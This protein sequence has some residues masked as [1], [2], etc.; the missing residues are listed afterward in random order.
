MPRK[1][2]AQPLDEAIAQLLKKQPRS[3]PELTEALTGATYWAIK[4]TVDRMEKRGEVVRLEERKAKSGRSEPVYLYLPMKLTDFME[5]VDT[6][7]AEE[8]KAGQEVGEDVIF[9]I[10]TRT[11][12]DPEFDEE[13]RLAYFKK[14]AVLL[15]NEDPRALL[16]RFGK[17]LFDVHAHS[18]AAYERA[19][20]GGGVGS[21]REE[22]ERTIDTVERMV[23]VVFNRNLGI[24][25]IREAEGKPGNAELRLRFHK[26]PDGQ[27]VRRT[28][29]AFVQDAVERRLK[30]A[31]VGGT[32]LEKIKVK[33]TERNYSESGTDASVRKFDLRMLPSA[34]ERTRMAI[35]TAAAVRLNFNSEAP[36]EI[37]ARPEPR[38]W[39]YYTEDDAIDKGLLIPPDAYLLLDDLIWERLGSAAMNLR[40][41]KKDSECFEQDKE[42]RVPDILFR[43]GRIFPLE[44]LFDDYC[45][46]GIHGRIVRR[47]IEA[48]R[49]MLVKVS[50]YYPELPRPLYC[51]VVKRPEVTILAPL[52][53]WYMKYGANPSIW[54]DM[55]DMKFI[56]RTPMSD[57]RVA[58]YLFSA[59]AEQLDPDQ[60]WITCRFVRPFVSMN[61]K[62]AKSSADTYDGWVEFLRSEIENQ[63]H[64]SD[65][66]VE[67]YAELCARAAV[68]SFYASLPSNVRGA[69]EAFLTPRYEVLLP[70][71]LVESWKQEQT[72]QAKAYDE[73][74]LEAVVAAIG[75]KKG[76]DVYP[77]SLEGP[78]GVDADQPQFLFPKATTY[79]HLY[80]KEVS[81]VHESD[82]RGYLLKIIVDVTKASRGRRLESRGGL[83]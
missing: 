9:S 79:A 20:A 65:P 1:R 41:Y 11:V 25:D 3:V 62:I 70:R 17:W 16:L 12:N 42:G 40:Q 64:P 31:V 46:S 29:R 26:R 48:F 74:V 6:A 72:D 23:R 32:V 50:N 78:E 8:K 61:Q 45:Q 14:A 49:D 2:S 43:D 38:Q 58:H 24:P 83:S 37:D 77:D 57:Q 75:D 63:A 30:F 82:F 15:A 47:S 71:Q 13:K 44:H 53:F 7:G 73:K 28:D 51:G 67:P 33:R 5:V 22:I 60:R 59:L 52:V 66:D 54:P 34:F 56:L 81:G 18:V 68:T 69:P 4:K 10:V 55:D 19:V 80:S 39:R 27:G 21:H 35:V 36:P 76:L